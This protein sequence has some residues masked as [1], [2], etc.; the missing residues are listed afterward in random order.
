MA[1]WRR[2]LYAV[3]LAQTLTIIGFNLRTPFLPLFLADLGTTSVEQQTLW[4][5]VINA[6]G[7]AVMTI[8]APLWGVVAD[9]YGRKPMVLR[10]MFA[11]ACTIGLMALATS[12]W[13]LLILRF[14]EGGLTGTVTATTALVATTVPK[15][16]LG[17]SLGLMQMAIFSG[18]S[19]GPLLGGVLADTIG[20]RSTF[21]LAGSLL[22][23]SGLLVLFLA[24]ERFERPASHPD[25]SAP[26]QP[27]L[28]TLLLAPAM[29]AMILVLF[30]LRAASSSIQPIMPLFV[31]QLSQRTSGVASLAGIAMGVMGLTSA[32]ASVVLGR[33]GDRIGPR[34]ILI[35]SVLLSGLLYLPQAAAHSVTQLILLQAVFGL[36][37]G[38]A[39]PTANAIVAHLTPPARRGAIYG[40]T[41]A[42]TSLGGFVG[43]L[44]G[45]ALAAAA[46]IRATFLLTGALLLAMGLWVWRA[47]PQQVG[48]PAASRRERALDQSRS[49]R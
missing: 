17:F 39:L 33:A 37:V 31:E 24:E 35:A 36:A 4:A 48:V 11:G 45:A 30:S 21:A 46:S 23:I 49:L 41:A 7:A 32:L 14:L 22:F 8:A 38:G 29:L 43:P 34:S 27:P 28:R 19:V 5:G 18:S 3:W 16:R 9:R 47:I 6:G 12:P 40:F 2:T 42:A 20:F 1:S 26:D 15:E 44:G 13:H 10:S 25:G